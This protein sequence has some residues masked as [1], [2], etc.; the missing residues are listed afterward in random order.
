MIKLKQFLTEVGPRTWKG[1]GPAWQQSTLEN[2]MEFNIPFSVKFFKKLIG[3]IPISTFHMTD[4]KGLDKLKKLQ[5][6]KKSIS[7]FNATTRDSDLSKGKGI[8][9]EGGILLHLT[10]NLLAASLKDMGSR[11]DES[12]RRWIRS[13]KLHFLDKGGNF[14][15]NILVREFD[16]TK[17][18]K[19]WTEFGK[20]HDGEF[21]KWIKKNH[22]GWSFIFDDVPEGAPPWVNKDTYWYKSFLQYATNKEKSEL[23]KDYINTVQKVLLKHQKQIKKHFGRRIR[24][25]SEYDEYNELVIYNIKIED[26]LLTPKIWKKLSDS[27]KKT[28]ETTGKG[29]V[30][31]AKKVGKEISSFIT[32]RGGKIK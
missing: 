20:N 14:F 19:Y 17:S 15:R 12:G 1:A 30:I 5:G 8:Q 22:P 4:L 6:K 25:V 27:E 18:K 13:G 28:V 32:S 10:G 26:I 31:Y 7:T 2:V 21:D 11:P 9:T 23:I 29:K 24:S 3:D 16:K